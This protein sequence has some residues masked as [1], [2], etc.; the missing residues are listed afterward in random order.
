MNATICAAIRSRSVIQFHYDG[1]VRIAEPYCHGT[2]RAGH[3]VVRA[4]QTG[5]YSSSGDPVAWKL[6]EVS[7]MQALT[8]T[9]SSFTANRAGYNP[10]DA[11]MSSV[12]CHV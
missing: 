8:V 9:T 7:K 11:H 4:Y 2:S 3:E 5:G 1:G 10:N 12:H 6:F